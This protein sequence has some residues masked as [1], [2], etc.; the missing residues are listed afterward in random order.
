MQEK[1]VPVTAAILVKEGKI[2]LAQRLPGDKMAG[3]WEFPG[4]KTEPGETPQT[5][6]ERELE[7][8]FGIIAKTGRFFAASEY[9]YEH[10]YI[11]LE[12]YFITN[13]VGEFRLNSHAAIAWVS[14]SQLLQYPLSPADIDIALQLSVLPSVNQFAE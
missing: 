9:R 4:G 11:R 1:P 5:C 12:A 6:L 10:I 8:E 13:W 3:F 14:L 2:L 7:E